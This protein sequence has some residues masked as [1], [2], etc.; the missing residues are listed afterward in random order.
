MEI[1]TDETKIALRELGTLDPPQ[2]KTKIC[3]V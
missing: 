3:K 1:V 2:K